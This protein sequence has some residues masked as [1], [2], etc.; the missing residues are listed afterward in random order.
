MRRR[1][2]Q[3][4][5]F[6]SR[7]AGTLLVT[8][9]WLGGRRAKLGSGSRAALHLVQRRRHHRQHSWY[10]GSTHGNNI[11]LHWTVTGATSVPVGECQPAITFPGPN[12]RLHPDVLG[13]E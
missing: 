4:S 5:M 2:M 7:L 1:P 10:R 12:T 8:I 3:R 6:E 11:V 13:H 9:G